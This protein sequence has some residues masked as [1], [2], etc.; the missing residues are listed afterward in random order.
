M[1][2]TIPLPR[3]SPLHMVVFREPDGEVQVLEVSDNAMAAL[4]QL[5]H[6]HPVSFNEEDQKELMNWG[7]ILPSVFRNDP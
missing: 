7:V 1:E 3:E 4:R 2:P 6:G 5:E